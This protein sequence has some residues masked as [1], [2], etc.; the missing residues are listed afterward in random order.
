[1]TRQ[2]RLRIASG[3]SLGN[4]YGKDLGFFGEIFT[5]FASLAAIITFLVLFLVLFLFAVIRA[6]TPV[7]IVILA[8]LAIFWAIKHF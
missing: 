5:V 7:A 2:Q 6:L 8:V 4:K 1:M 3:R